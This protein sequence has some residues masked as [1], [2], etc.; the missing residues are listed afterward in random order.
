MNQDNPEAVSSK[1][2]IGRREYSDEDR[3]VIN[4]IKKQVQD[5]QR[6]EE[7]LYSDLLEKIPN[8][9]QI[10]KDFLWDYVFNDI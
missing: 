8:L 10:D 2:V 6:Q 5:L 3:L 4:S 9:T 7:A 1:L